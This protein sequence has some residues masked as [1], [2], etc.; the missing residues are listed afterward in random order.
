[1]AGM[2]DG[3]SSV[4]Y[5]ACVKLYRVHRMVYEMSSS[6]MPPREPAFEEKA[7]IKEALIGEDSIEGLLLLRKM[8]FTSPQAAMI[9]EA[10]WNHSWYDLGIRNI[11]R[12]NLRTYWEIRDTI[13]PVW[14]KTQQQP[15]APL[16]PQ[17]WVPVAIV[18]IVLVGMYLVNPSWED[19]YSWR[20]PCGLYIGTYQEALSWFALIGVSA[21][22]K[23]L[24]TRIGFEG[25][26]IGAHTYEW[27]KP[28]VVTDRFHFFG[29]MRFECWKVPW[30]RVFSLQYID[31]TY[32]G[33]L[34]CVIAERY[35]LKKGG[36]DHFLPR[37]PMVVP[38]Q[39][40]CRILNPCH[41]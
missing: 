20:P 13:R 37:G 31:T 2:L 12:C 36:F 4:W 23:P 32:V 30:F 15:P 7:P 33:Q 14:I 28:P 41:E 10:I 39:H 22:Q 40:V 3:V 19:E 27:I 5:D 6:P 16:P 11:H 38:E 8:G 29:T 9:F 1:M 24:Y 34:S 21:E 18:G 25:F 26:V 35:T 17:V